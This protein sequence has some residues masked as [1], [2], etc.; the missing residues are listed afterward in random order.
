MHCDAEPR[1][2]DGTQV[3]ICTMG[4][5]NERVIC[6]VVIGFLQIDLECHPAA[7]EFDRGSLH[8]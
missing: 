4:K 8:L 6:G 1:P 3:T 2:T 7:L 5:R